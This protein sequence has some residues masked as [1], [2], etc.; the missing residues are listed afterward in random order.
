MSNF[1]KVTK[2][3]ILYLLVVGVTAILMPALMYKASAESAEELIIVLSKEN[4]T[5]VERTSEI[6]TAKLDL[7]LDSEVVRQNIETMLNSKNE[8]DVDTVIR[9][10]V[11][12]YRLP[13]TQEDQET[14]SRYMKEKRVYFLE[15]SAKIIMYVEEYEDKLH[16]PIAGFFLRITGF[17]KRI[18]VKQEL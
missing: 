18:R 1:L 8:E 3:I 6:I 4:L 9:Q 10:V 16:D 5:I 11:R 13:I 14:F 12:N 17:P 15:N 7:A 2:N